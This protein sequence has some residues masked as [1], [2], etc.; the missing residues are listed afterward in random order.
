[1]NTQIEKR[2][3][4]ISEKLEYVLNLKDLKLKKTASVIE[5]DKKS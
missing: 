1:M 4:Q 2:A 3:I 5:D